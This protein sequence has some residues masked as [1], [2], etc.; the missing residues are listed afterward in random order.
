[1]PGLTAN[2]EAFR[3]LY[4][5]LLL[6]MGLAVVLFLLQGTRSGLSTL[7]GGL[8]Y[9]LPTL[10]FVWRVFA[11]A[12]ARA[13]KQFLVLFIAGEMFK[14]VLSAILFI[15]I[16]KYLPVN[17]LSVLIGFIGAIIAFWIASLLLLGRHEEVSP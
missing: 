10:A 15:C 5:Q 7:L 2:K 16:V 11:R 4:W 6:I 1:M 9:W 14:L 13:A 3:I 12:T 17:L 8:A